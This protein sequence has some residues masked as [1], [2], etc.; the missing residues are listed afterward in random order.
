MSNSEELR[1]YNR[2]ATSPLFSEAIS[3]ATSIESAIEIA[4]NHGFDV[5][6]SAIRVAAGIQL[7]GSR[8]NNANADPNPELSES[9]LEAVSEAG[10][11]WKTNCGPISM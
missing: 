9:D 11:W 7:T 8:A 5:D 1:F 6:E 2:M 3:G 10:D 4:A